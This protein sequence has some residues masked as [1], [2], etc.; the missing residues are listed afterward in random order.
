MPD[1]SVFIKLSGIVETCIDHQAWL[2][3]FLVWLESRDECYGG[4]TQEVDEDG[5]AKG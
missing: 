2:D 5:N 4:G 1:V 3:A